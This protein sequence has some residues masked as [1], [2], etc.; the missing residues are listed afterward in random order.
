M[1]KAN[2]FPPCP[3]PLHLFPR[4]P[5]PWPNFTP[6][7][8]ACH[9]EAKTILIHAPSVARLQALR[10]KLGRPMVILSAYRTEAYNRACGGA[11]GSMHLAARAFDVAMTGHDPH[12]FEAAARN[13]GFT[14][15]GFYPDQGFMH[16][17]TGPAREWG[18]RWPDYEDEDPEDA[19]GDDAARL[20][21][22]DDLKSAGFGTGGRKIT[23][24]LKRKLA[25]RA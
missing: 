22:L 8:L 23:H 11:A 15:F 16:I 21:V 10:N 17:D 4:E 12:E 20:Q 9:D 19:Q 25:A 7:E 3:V 24:P 5:W 6:E 14:G 13:A 1:K 2:P 18:D